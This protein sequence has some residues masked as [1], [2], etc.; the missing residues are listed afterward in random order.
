MLVGLLRMVSG[1]SGSSLRTVTVQYEVRDGL[2]EN[3]PNGECDRPTIGIQEGRTVTLTGPDGVLLGASVVSNGTVVDVDL[4]NSDD[5]EGELCRFEFTFLNIP[6]VATYRFATQ[7][8]P[9]F[10]VLP[11]DIVKADGWTLLLTTRL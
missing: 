11:L 6:E 9:D 2:W 7:G 10:P 1:C 4:P 3:L 5:Y 8:G